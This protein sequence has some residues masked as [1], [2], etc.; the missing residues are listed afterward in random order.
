MNHLSPRGP[1]RDLLAL[2]GG[3]LCAT[4]LT[5]FQAPD[6]FQQRPD[7][8]PDIL[9]ILADDVR[10][11]AL[12]CTGSQ[13]VATPHFDRLAGEGA[14]FEQAFVTTS[15][16]CPSRASLLTGKYAHT[17]GVSYNQLSREFLAQHQTI[18]DHLWRAGYQ[19]AFIG[20]WH[21]DEDSSNP[22]RGFDHWVSFRKKG[23]H[24][25]PRLNVNG[26]LQWRPGGFNSDLCT[27]EA[28]G[29][30]RERGQ[31][32]YF[33]MLSLKG[34]N[35]PYHSPKQQADLLKDLK[36]ELPESMRD[37]EDTMP[38]Q[39]WRARQDEQQSAP[40]LRHESLEEA[41]RGY[42]RLVLN[43][44]ENLG[45][46]LAALEET[47]RLQHTLILFVSDGGYL[48]GEHGVY[49][50]CLPWDPAIRVP[51]LAR[52][53]GEVEAGQRIQEMV[54]TTDILPTLLELAGVEPPE[55]VDGHSLRGLWSGKAVESW[56]RDILYVAPYMDV[57]GGSLQ[58]AVRDREYKYL[59]LR[60]GAI[61]EALFDLVAD[62][63]ERHNLA[64][65]PAQR[66]RLEALRARMRA[67]FGEYRISDKWWEPAATAGESIGDE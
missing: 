66:E 33:L 11:D 38:S 32:P 18:A 44:D 5:S 17:I 1:R 30:I 16:S 7:A 52:L 43:L 61:E 41:W 15:L 51:L 63:G 48:W 22:R 2:A 55:D 36:L 23:K 27:D 45:R 6:A 4:L 56:R 42:H 39:L 26:E 14:L 9:L 3:V 65:D 62:P 34:C 60:A 19:T 25:S 37:G 21:F 46:L 67:L 59:R 53:P 58:L 10:H 47:G 29:W 35:T 24:L 12:G 57:R 20:K 49:R 54:L 50:K 8:R 31:K 64:G 40:L 13:A 28:I